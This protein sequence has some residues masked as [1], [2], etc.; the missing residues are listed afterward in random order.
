MRFPKVTYGIYFFKKTLLIIVLNA[1]ECAAGRVWMTASY[2]MISVSR[3][4]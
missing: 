1:L 2:M 4:L 3:C